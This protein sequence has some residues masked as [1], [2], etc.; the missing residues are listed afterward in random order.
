MK[1]CYFCNGSGY[2]MYPI[3]ADGATFGSSPTGEEKIKCWACDKNGKITD[4]FAARTCAFCGAT[5]DNP[6]TDKW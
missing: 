3:Y 5:Y 6:I 2:E 4:E 1:E